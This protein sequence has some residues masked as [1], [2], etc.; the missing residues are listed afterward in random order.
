[1][2]SAG[3]L[4]I[5]PARGGS[6]GIPRKN[7]IGLAGKPLIVHT[8]DAAKKSGIF[9]K[10]VVSTDSKEIEKIS[11]RYG[12]QV[13]MR[14]GRLAKDT[15]PTEPVMLHA[16]EWLRRTQGYRPGVIALLQPTSP[17]RNGFDISRAYEKFIKSGADSLLSV[18]PNR[19]FLWEE[20]RGALRPI[21]Y[22]YLRRPIRQEMKRQF[23]ENGAIY[24]TKYKTFIRFKNRLGGMVS[25]Y[26]M[27]EERSIDIDGYIDLLTA[28]LIT[29]TRERG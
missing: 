20:K 8:I 9:D 25:S 7:I 21:N 16:L 5:I 26:V 19:S 11:K 27:D 4:A 17:L 10:I 6:K 1:M 24:L 2:A 18:T 29:Q 13:I 28:K 3:V 23:R 22:N 14:P 15:S 12:V